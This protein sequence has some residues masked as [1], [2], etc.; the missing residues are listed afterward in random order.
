[1]W[2]VEQVGGVGKSEK[3]RGMERERESAFCCQGSRIRL[4]LSHN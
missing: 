1:M 2:G 4:I 3:G